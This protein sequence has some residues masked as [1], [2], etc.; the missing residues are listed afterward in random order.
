MAV[1][2][3]ASMLVYVVTPN[4]AAPE[5][6]ATG[7]P[8]Q[9]CSE[10]IA[11]LLDSLEQRGERIV[12]PTPALAEVLVKASEA[13]AEY[14]S[15]LTASRHFSIRPFDTLA[16]VEHAAIQRERQA[17]GTIPVRRLVRKRSST[18]RF[19]PLL[20]SAPPKRSTR[21]ILT[22]PSFAGISGSPV[23]ASQTCRFRLRTLK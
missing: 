18:T 17:S 10:R 9:H 23:R 6:K 22:S 20:A 16:A 4:A 21:T 5:D 1:V 11:H 2:F 7:Q 19:S 15:R 13:A 14:L 8:V 12:I 3:D